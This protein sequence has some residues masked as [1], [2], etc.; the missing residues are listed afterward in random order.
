MK[1]GR[2]APAIRGD[3]RGSRTAERWSVESPGGVA[4]LDIPAD[5]ARERAFEIYCSL[6][7]RRG[8]GAAASHALRV[9]V[10]GA[11]Q[12]SRRVPTHAGAADTL[13]VRLRRVVPVGRPLRIGA[14]G[15]ADGAAVLRLSI[16]AEE[17]A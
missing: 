17:D 14:I 13:D 2:E 10:D 5:A 4:L 6:A 9:L 8:D 1:A 7:V 12:W 3:A 15:E 16:V 11:Q